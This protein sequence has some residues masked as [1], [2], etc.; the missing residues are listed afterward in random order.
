[1]TSVARAAF[2]LDEPKLGG[3]LLNFSSVT[4]GSAAGTM[5]PDGLPDEATGRAF[6]SCDALTA[7]R[8]RRTIPV[9][10]RVALDSLPAA[11]MT[12]V[13]LGAAPE[14]EGTMVAC[15]KVFDVC[16]ALSLP[17][18][19]D[20]DGRSESAG[21]EAVPVRFPVGAAPARLVPL[22]NET[23]VLDALVALEERDWDEAMLAKTSAVTK[24]VKLT[25][26]CD[27]LRVAF[28]AIPNRF[29]CR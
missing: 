10:L 16:R 7:D 1:M 13:M 20:G 15:T 5:V 23:V 22:A 14:V 26:F 18:K 9:T 21:T 27:T 2:L 11:G 8:W 6:P 29:C 19:R 24:R 28:D 17:L 12:A 3:R 25:I 4:S